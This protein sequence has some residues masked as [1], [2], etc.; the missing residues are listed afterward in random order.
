MD[1]KSCTQLDEAA[2]QKILKQFLDTNV[3][4]NIKV[5]SY[6]APDL[7]ER[8]FLEQYKKRHFFKSC[9]EPEYCDLIFKYHSVLDYIESYDVSNS[10]NM[11]AKL[12]TFLANFVLIELQK[13][14][15]TEQS[16]AVVNHSKLK[17]YEFLI[18]INKIARDIR[19]NIDDSVI[20]IIKEF[21]DISFKYD[22]NIVN[23]T[24]PYIGIFD[25][26]RGIN[27]LCLNL[28]KEFIFSSI[29]FLEPDI[30]EKSNVFT[31]YIPFKKHVLA[32]NSFLSGK[33]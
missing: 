28:I 29:L 14:I 22:T 10:T 15:A 12:S 24:Y 6:N 21:N 32:L 25:F 13:I 2:K 33:K 3:E 30:I 16:I 19:N 11:F 26:Y 17:Q 9:S 31:S 8:F 7:M 4:K 5:S 27:E 20:S 18:P 23:I 1:D